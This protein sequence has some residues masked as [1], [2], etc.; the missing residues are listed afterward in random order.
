MA[1]KKEFLKKGI[2]RITAACLAY[3]M[4]QSALFADFA[5]AIFSEGTT[6]SVTTTT[7]TA[8]PTETNTETAA[9]AS[10]TTATTASAEPVTTVPEA[11]VEVVTTTPAATVPLD[12][13]TN[14]PGSQTSSV[15]I[16]KNGESQNAEQSTEAWLEQDIVGESTS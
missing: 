4:V 16:S 15:D 13:S 7:E 5:Y 9:T 10:T 11:N 3:A 8:A 12:T 2:R 1:M 14:S 6:T